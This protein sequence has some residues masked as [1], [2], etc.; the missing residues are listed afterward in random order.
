MSAK[1]VGSKLLILEECMDECR[2]VSEIAKDG[3]LWMIS[4]RSFGIHL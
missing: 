2:D 1:G 3:T 4:E